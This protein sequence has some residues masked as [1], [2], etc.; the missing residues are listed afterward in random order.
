MTTTPTTTTTTP[1]STPILYGPLNVEYLNE[2][3]CELHYKSGCSSTGSI[4]HLNHSV[5][6]EILEKLLQEAQKDSSQRQSPISLLPLLAPPQQTSSPP[7][8][9]PHTSH[10]DS[11]LIRDKEAVSEAANK[12]KSTTDTT[13]TTTTAEIIKK[14]D[15]VASNAPSSIVNVS[16]SKSSALGFTD[17]NYYDDDDVDLE[18]VEDDEEDDDDDD[19]DTNILDENG[20]MSSYGT[21][22]RSRAKFEGGKKVN[23]SNV[24]TT[25][26][27]SSKR[28]KR[29]DE[30]A[31]LL[32]ASSSTPCPN[33]AK[34]KKQIDMLMERQ[35]ANEKELIRM[36]NEYE[37]RLLN[38]SLELG[39]SSGSG[40]NMITRSSSSTISSTSGSNTPTTHITTTNKVVTAATAAFEPVNPNDWSKYFASRPQI[41]PPKEWNFVHPNSSKSKYANFEYVKPTM[42]IEPVKT[43]TSSK[44]LSRD[45]GKLIFTHMA[46]IILGAT[47]MFLVMKRHFNCKNSIY[48]I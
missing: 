33:C 3:W 6:P 4:S 25:N 18:Y 41:Q 40:K 45:L 34:Q 2:S 37:V 14:C 19:N 31:C 28:L 47:L 17:L 11:N 48:F 32:G 21:T 15:S 1:P 42:M 12:S 7:P 24:T 29:D 10:S 35:L 5:N 13:A 9:Q 22:V 30:V 8:L 46:S 16:S 27:S 44:V 43:S 20:E 26:S 23:S 38:K 36:R 39:S